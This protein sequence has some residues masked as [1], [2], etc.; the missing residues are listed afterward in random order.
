MDELGRLASIDFKTSKE[1]K[2]QP[3]DS[4]R[5]TLWSAQFGRGEEYAEALAQRHFERAETRAQQIGGSGGSLEPPEH[6]S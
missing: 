1:M 6:L 3:V 4:Q 5:I 2:W